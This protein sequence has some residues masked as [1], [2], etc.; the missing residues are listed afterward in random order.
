MNEQAEYTL[1]ASSQ[2]IVGN[3]Y[4]DEKLFA[5]EAYR[6]LLGDNPLRAVLETREMVR[7][8]CPSQGECSGLESKACSKYFEPFRLVYLT[9]PHINVSHAISTRLGGVSE[10]SYRGLNIGFTTDDNPQDVEENRRRLTAASHIPLRAVLSMVHGVEVVKVEGPCEASGLTGSSTG[11][12]EPESSLPDSEDGGIDSTAGLT[13]G[14]AC[15]TSCPNCPMMITTADCVPVLIYDP[16]HKAVGLAHAG[17]RGTVERISRVT[18]EAMQREFDSDPTQ[19]KVGIGPSIGPCCFEVGVEVAQ[20]F[21]QAFA[22]ISAEEELILANRSGAEVRYKVDLWL[23]NLIALHEAG[24]RAE[25][26][27]LSGI[28]SMCHEELCFSYRRDKRVSGRMA[29]AVVLS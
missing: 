5:N 28:C 11:A 3:N 14:D 16:I 12:N 6:R 8:R 27:C 19:L 24:V 2:E 13:L 9:F 29:T 21:S 23:A 20:R 10:G 17:W 25:N 1:L 22:D 15:I 7:K 4:V 18:V 26:I